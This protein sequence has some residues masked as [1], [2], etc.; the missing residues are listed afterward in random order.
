MA[1]ENTDVGEL[2]P[3]DQLALLAQ[4]PGYMEDVAR[5]RDVRTFQMVQPL[6]IGLLVPTDSRYPPRKTPQGP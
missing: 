6:A 4:Q 5:E 2:V 3:L 1:K